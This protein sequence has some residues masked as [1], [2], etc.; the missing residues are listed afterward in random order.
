MSSP[1][2]VRKY[3]LLRFTSNVDWVHVDPSL[4]F[5]LSLLAAQNNKIITVF[6]GYR[7]DKYSAAHGGFAG[8]PHTR[9]IAVDAMIGNKPI[10]NV[11]SASQF[12]AAGLI[13]GNQPNFY[14]GKRDPSHVQLAGGGK[15][16]S[17]PVPSSDGSSSEQGAGQ[18]TT[19]PGVQNDQTQPVVPQPGQMASP[20]TQPDI[21]STLPYQPAPAS[22]INSTN[23]F[24]AELWNRIAS[25]PAS[26]PD[27]QLLAQNAQYS[28]GG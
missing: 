10:G 2:S 20:Q 17:S 9:H 22:G 11:I 7:N 5:K 24:V 3:P 1:S 28:S 19:V 8:D 6:S 13:T 25:Q 4:L 16:G 12:A 26:S 21:G 23:Q 18:D 14:K 27:T 15:T